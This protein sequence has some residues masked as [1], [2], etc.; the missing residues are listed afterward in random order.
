MTAAQ[1]ASISELAKDSNE[2]P[3]ENKAGKRFLQIQFLPGSP[4][5]LLR[6]KEEVPLTSGCEPNDDQRG[7]LFRALF[8]RSKCASHIGHQHI[9]ELDANQLLSSDYKIFKSI[10]LPQARIRRDQMFVQ[11]GSAKRRIQQRLVEFVKQQAVDEAS[12]HTSAWQ[13]TPPATIQ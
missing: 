11:V 7:R 6:R 3:W 1:A 4:A 5:V 10:Q 12:K 8:Y 2:G 13:Q 9:V